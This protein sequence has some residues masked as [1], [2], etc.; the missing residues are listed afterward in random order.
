PERFLV[1]SLQDDLT[2]AVKPALVAVLGAVAL[3]LLMACANVANLM[4]ARAVTRQ[5]ELA[6]RA[7]LGAGRLRLLRQMLTESL[8]LAGAGGLCGW[9]LAWWLT[10]LLVWL[11][12][13]EA[14]GQIGQLAAIRLD[15]RVLGFTLLT[16]WLSS[17]L[18]GLAPALQGSQ[19]DLNVTLKESGRGGLL[20]RQRLRQAL[21]VGEVA[22]AVVLLAGAGL[23]LRSFVNLLNV[24]P[25]FQAENLLTARVVLPYLRYKDQAKRKQFE[26]QVLERLAATPG[27]E[28]VGAI[29]H[30]PVTDFSLMVW[31]RAQG[32]PPEEGQKLG[33]TPLG[34]ISPDYFR[35]LGIGLR[36][37]RYFDE[38]DTAEA[39]RVLILSEMLARQL[40]PNEDPLGKRIHVPGPPGPNK[41]LPVVVGVV[42]DVRHQGL[43]QAVRAQVFAPFT[44]FASTRMV[45]AVRTAGEPQSMAA[46]LRAAV[47]AT[48][49]EAPVYEVMTME[50]RLRDSVAAR[51]FILLL[52]GLFALLA[53][54]LAAVG[55]YGVLAYAV[56]QRTHEVGIRM[57]LG[58]E[59]RDVARL[60]L[61]QGMALVVCGVMI[62]LLGAF[63]LTRVM[64]G[65]LF[66]VKATDPLTFT[67]VAFLLTLVALAA[68]WLPARRA[69]R[70]DP[71]VALRHE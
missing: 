62:G 44:Q 27:I 34:L 42:G 48:D 21:L 61:K 17:V 3:V 47:L 33:A 24:E 8:L 5:K 58:A 12:P 50:E 53:L 66:G 2:G 16:A 59:G 38:R 15:G 1:N 6:I 28:H 29:N 25:G 30:L 70:V 40:F 13:A 9:A 41:E 69:T 11:S 37:G 64:A 26:Q 4:L 46:A 39:P 54:A 23:L 60:F 49:P 68:C 10:R 71:L 55:V 65:L 20:Q 18:I 56:T 31:L 52:V 57:A 7:A 43:E 32:R 67:G 51:R 45:L 14:F 36:A 35:T 19:P 63:G 22:L